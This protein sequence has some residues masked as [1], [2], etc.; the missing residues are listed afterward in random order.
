MSGGTSLCPETPNEP[1]VEWKTKWKLQFAI[2][3]QFVRYS[4]SLYFNEFQ[5][6]MKEKSRR[7]PLDVTTGI[8]QEWGIGKR[9]FGKDWEKRIW[10]FDRLIWPI[11]G[12][13][14]EIWGLRREKK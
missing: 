13:K 5:I 9:R 2:N 7:N 12:Y 8:G 6:S 11:I 14:P 3:A 10:L 4:Q 1:G